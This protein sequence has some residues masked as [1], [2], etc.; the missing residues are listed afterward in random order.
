MEWF[1]ASGER[2]TMIN[3]RSICEI[4]GVEFIG[5]QRCR[6]EEVVGFGDLVDW[7]AVVHFVVNRIRRYLS[8]LEWL[9]LQM[10]VFPLSIGHETS[11][12]PS[13]Q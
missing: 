9:F 8:R 2:N 4:A 1:R 5:D 3:L 13:C 12:K 10:T 6:R 11:W 7:C